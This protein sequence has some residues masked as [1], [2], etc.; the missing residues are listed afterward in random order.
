M[1]QDREIVEHGDVK[2]LSTSSPEPVANPPTLFYIINALGGSLVGAAVLLSYD[3]VLSG[4]FLLSALVCPIWFVVVAFRGLIGRDWRLGLLRVAIPLLTLVIVLGNNAIQWKIGEA[5]MERII[6]A[7]E[8]FHAANGQYPKKLNDLVPQYLPSIPRER[9][10]LF[11]TG[12]MYF[13]FPDQSH[14]PMLVWVKIP[15]F[16][17]KI[18]SFE[19]KS[20]GYLD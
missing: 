12:F 13:N 2:S 5:N 19:D 10:C 1:S 4:S 8:S 11:D 18:Y 14:S 20:W 6:T 7:C 16:G 15:P 17:R 9:Y 3:A